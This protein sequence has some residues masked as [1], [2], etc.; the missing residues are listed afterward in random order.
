MDLKFVKPSLEYFNDLK[1]YVSE[2]TSREDAEGSNGLYKAINEN[3][4]SNWLEW[5]DNLNADTYMVMVK[6]RIVGLIN[7]RYVLEGRLL[8]YGGHIGFNIRPSER[9]KGYATKALKWMLK[10]AC[11][12]GLNEVRIDCYSD[13]IGSIKTIEACGGVFLEEEF[14]EEKN[15]VIV[16]YNVDTRK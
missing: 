14:I 2:L 15:K 11:N 4:F 1:E 5:L 7:I 6:D 13:N 9:R 8:R 3:T 12:K 16:K 10:E